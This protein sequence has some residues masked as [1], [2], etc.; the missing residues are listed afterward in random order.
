MNKEVLIYIVIGILIVL[1]IGSVLITSGFLKL[2]AR[3]SESS[4]SYGNMPQECQK[5]ANQ[6]LES[7]KEHLGHHS[8]TLYCLDYF[9][10]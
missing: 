8:N 5:P 7:W 9:K 3:S 2:G 10:N 1:V 4:K 6:D